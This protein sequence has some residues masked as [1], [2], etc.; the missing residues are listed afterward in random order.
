[1]DRLK[2]AN[3]LEGLAIVREFHDYELSQQEPDGH[4]LM[5]CRWLVEL[6]EERHKREDGHAQEAN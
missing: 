5:L 6:V 2:R 4:F 3:D 1:M